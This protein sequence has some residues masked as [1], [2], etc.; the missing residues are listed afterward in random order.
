M[1]IPLI[2][3]DEPFT[4]PT[5]VELPEGVPT[6]TEFAEA[7]TLADLPSVFDAG[8]SALAPAGPI[9]PGY[10]LYSGPPS[11]AFDL[12][13]GFPVAAAPD[14]FT[15]GTFPSGRA[16]ALSHL[17]SYDGLGDSWGRLM[18]EF[19]DRGLGE[20]KLIGEVYVTDPSV[21]PGTELRTDLFVVYG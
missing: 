7:I 16:L 17:G 21:T 20:A 10:A 3:R 9:G 13:I 19:A 6:V 4:A 14:G 11:G 12:E 5:E 15:A 8:F 2:L 18:T 1:S